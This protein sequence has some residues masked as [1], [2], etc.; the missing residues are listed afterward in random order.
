MS[1]LH[2]ETPDT[3]DTRERILRATLRLME[4]W[5][6][7]SVRV[8]DIAH[9]AGVSRQAVY[10]HFGSRTELLVATARYLDERLQLPERLQQVLHAKG[11]AESIDAYT[12]FWA[13]YIP[14]IYGLATA[15]LTTRATDEAA[16]TAWTDRMTALY[17]GCRAVVL[18]LE[19]EGTLAAEWTVE[20]A[21]DFFWAA[22][23]L[24]VWERL[25]RE[26]GWTQAQYLEGMQRV[27]RRALLT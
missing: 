9:A 19:E 3:A 22:L 21:A 1:S 14:E 26:R 5:R 24:E 8:E 4:Q 7:Q 11:G 13:A 23:A 15:L 17:E 6:G 20:T 27:I 16:A 10:L 25:T 12:A 18:C 2:T